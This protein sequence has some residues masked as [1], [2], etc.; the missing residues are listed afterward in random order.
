[1]GGRG[2]ASTN[3][4]G[5]YSKAKYEQRLKT[6]N[7]FGEYHYHATTAAGIAG[8]Q[9]TGGINPSR[10]HMGNEVYMAK[11]E[12]AAKDWTETSTGGKVVVRV[13]NTYLAKTDYMDFDRDKNGEGSTERRIPNSVV[14]VKAANGNWYPIDVVQVRNGRVIHSRF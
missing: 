5:G 3:Q 4:Y 9:K 14:Q 11:T 13:K 1:M 10:G 8:M 7:E 2:S 12:Q 6:L